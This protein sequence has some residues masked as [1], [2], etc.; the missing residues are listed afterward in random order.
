L[1]LEEDLVAR[2]KG[3]AVEAVAS[4]QFALKVMKLYQEKLTQ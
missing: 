2:P 4:E 1:S 3:A